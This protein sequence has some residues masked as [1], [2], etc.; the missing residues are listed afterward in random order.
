MADLPIIW[1]ARGV[2][3]NWAYSAQPPDTAYLATNARTKDASTG[4]LRGG[5][6]EGHS[7]FCPDQIDASNKIKRLATITYDNPNVTWANRASALTSAEIL[8]SVD[9]PTSEIAR[10]CVTDRLGNLYVTD[11]AAGVVKY[12]PR[13]NE[14]WRL[15]LPTE[16]E[17]HVIRALYVDDFLNVYAATSAG[18][19]GSLAR[20]WKYAPDTDTDTR[21]AWTHEP[22]GFVPD[23][24][25]RSDRLYYVVNFNETR[26]A[27][28][29]ALERID[30]STPRV[31]F[32]QVQAP[33]PVNAIS[34]NADGAIL[35]AHE[36]SVGRGINPQA[37][38]AD[39]VQQ[40]WS[41]LDLTD[42]ESR[43][44]SWHRADNIDGQGNAN[45]EEDD[46]VGVWIDSSGNGRHFYAAIGESLPATKGGTAVPIQAP[47]FATKAAAGGPGVRFNGTDQLMRSLPN[48]STAYGS[49]DGQ[50]STVP[51]YQAARDEGGTDIANTG[52]A[53]LMVMAVR[54]DLDQDNDVA[55][56]L[57]SHQDADHDAG[58]V[59]D[60]HILVNHTSDALD[61]DVDSNDK[62]Q[63]FVYEQTD[64]TTAGSSGGNGTGMLPATAN[65]SG[66]GGLDDGA[67]SPAFGEALNHKSGV[68]IVT[69]LCDGGFQAGTY[70]TTTTHSQ[71]RINGRPIDRYCSN[72]NHTLEPDY[73]GGTGLTDA[74][75][76]TAPSAGELN[77]FFKGWVLEKI[78]IAR[79]VDLAAATTEDIVVEHEKYGFSTT[80]VTGDVDWPGASTDQADT[81]LALLEGYM[82]HRHG[83][84]S[85]APGTTTEYGHPYRS[86]VPLAPDQP[87]TFNVNNLR[88]SS[89]ILAKWSGDSG[90]PI[91]SVQGANLGQGGIGYDV[92]V[93]PS[94]YIYS[95]GPANGAAVFVRR[96]DDTGDQ[97]TITGGD[98]WLGSLGMSQTN[99]TFPFT[100]PKLAVDQGDNVYVPV[101]VTPSSGSAQ[102]GDVVVY[103]SDGV[104]L[105]AFNRDADQWYAFACAV[106]PVFPPYPDSLTGQ[107]S[108]YFYAVG[109]T[110]DQNSDDLVNVVQVSQV[111]ETVNATAP[112]TTVHIAVSGADVTRFDTAASATPTGGTGALDATS[113]YVEAIS[114]FE[115]VYLADG[116]N[117]KVFD[118]RTD[119]VT[120]WEATSAGEIPPRCR[121]GTV[122]N[123]RI[124]LGRG[125]DP[126]EWFMS[127]K[128]TPLDWDFIPPLPLVT[129]AI[130][131]SDTRLGIVPDVVTGFVP[132]N[133]NVLLIGCDGSWHR[134]IGEPLDN[135]QF[136]LVTD[137]VGLAWNSSWTKDREGRIY[138][139]ESQGG[140]WVMSIDGAQRERL[141]RDTIERRLQDIDLADVYV[142]LEWDFRAEGL[143]VYV[144]P[145]GS[146]GTLRDH[147][148][149]EQQS[150]AWW[151]D[152]WTGTAKQ[153]SAAITLD[154][155]DPS[156]RVLLVGTE[157][158]HVLKADKSVGGD[159]GQ[160]IDWR[161]V[162]GPMTMPWS[163]THETRFR[164]L[165]IA[166][167]DDLDGCRWRLMRSNEP[168]VF[169]QG[170]AE[171]HLVP[172]LNSAQNRPAAAAH[173]WLELRDSS[174]E[175][176]AFE[177]ATIKAYRAG[178]LRPKA[179][180]VQTDL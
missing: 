96:I 140:I 118:P 10:R 117:Y 29:V 109:D 157:D 98:T 41:P 45:L 125:D 180:I 110:V 33:W 86:D 59:D 44:Y 112:R 22:G 171:G 135:D 39:P 124:V 177:Y 11:G 5:K 73:L 158:G 57:W 24:E 62:G 46:P 119:E 106:P 28:V 148:F 13:L 1:P 69:Y 79:T 90:L 84:K 88:S 155:D 122:W 42:A 92:E 149:W 137:Q 153:P 101:G 108:L 20:V 139:F 19:N 4:R 64:H 160:D 76:P 21:L 132:G 70:N 178:R 145:W 141:T 78:T 82:W 60:R 65:L 168:D 9:T 74:D 174:T 49:R 167:A 142:H 164:R 161:V 130:R 127:A 3:E 58:G 61:A 121:V 97:P 103:D 146:G 27:H 48:V 32:R 7:K 179:R 107:R 175:R 12:N 133:D 16:D 53:Y 111:T 143:H 38:D 129:Q 51:A 102:N 71:V 176:V 104:E 31:A 150:A 15:N 30:T 17:S 54:V 14:V 77:R 147:F 159:D 131:G 26:K 126:N 85:V 18:N 55:R 115:K 128:G 93:S 36:P 8:D 94:G 100:L 6:R 37:P 116:L 166:L 156:D 47:T 43:I 56:F 63:V 134:I 68:V 52:S 105:H 165:S 172:G 23:L 163:R 136:D 40:S 144:F 72:P 99:L 83:N 50:K 91:W 87:A 170:F 66:D 154:G 81:E 25:V 152:T 123:D 34:L 162:M 120:D 138:F 80:P 89:G 67:G 151:V 114:A 173:V 169:G 95:Y 113:R 2:N 35:T 75:M